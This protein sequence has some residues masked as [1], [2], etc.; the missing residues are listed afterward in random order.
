MSTDRQRGKKRWTRVFLAG[1][2]LTLFMWGP[3]EIAAQSDLRDLLDQAVE[4]QRQGRHQEA[5]DAYRRFLLEGPEYPEVLINL[6]AAYAALGDYAR[7]IDSYRK[8]LVLERENLPALLNLGL[9][10]YKSARYD[11]ALSPLSR[12]LELDPSQFNARML[13]ADSHFRLGDNERVIELLAPVADRHRDDRAFAYLLGTALIRQDRIS[14]GQVLVDR[15]LR[16]GDSAEA[17]LMMGSMFR[18][19]NELARAREEFQRALELN[20]NL[21]GAHSLLGTTHLISGNRDDALEMFRRE[22]Q[23]NPNDFEANFYLGVLLKQ[24]H[25]F[26]EALRHLE[27]ARLLR[28]QALDV[29][30]Q[31]S[32]AHLATRNHPVARSMLEEIVERAP[33][34]VE[35]RVSLATLYYRLDLREAG[36]RQREIVLQLNA[37]RQALEEGSQTEGRAYTGENPAEVPRPPR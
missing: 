24:D 27:K 17:R 11:E 30:Y 13:S 34:F 20:P 16:E 33:D 19:A 7:A 12:A 6:G 36:D 10:Y 25:E 18:K 1:C 29:Q 8:A 5:V 26:E 3:Y 23:L 9:A 31:I 22:L 32:T 35:A 37:E 28:P 14:E 21:P 2:C 4:H 15:I